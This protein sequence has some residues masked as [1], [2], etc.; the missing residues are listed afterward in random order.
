MHHR[1]MIEA[2]IERWSSFQG[3]TAYRWSIWRDGK[4]IH[5]GGNAHE[6]A[7]GAESEARDFCEQ[8]LGQPPDHVTHL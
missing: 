2:Y 7:N 5:M 3:T 6:D 8:S 4:R 1:A